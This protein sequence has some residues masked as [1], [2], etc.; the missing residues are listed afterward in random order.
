MISD[1]ERKKKPEII[2][3]QMEIDDI[4]AVYHL[5]EELFTSEGFPVLYRT[6]DAEITGY[7]SSDPDYCLVADAGGKAAGF[8]LANTIEK[9]VTDRK[10]HGYPACM[11]LQTQK[12]Y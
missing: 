7:F 5:G 4:S 6:C 1:N 10:K 8:T 3:R 12:Q 2:I 9:E 11:F